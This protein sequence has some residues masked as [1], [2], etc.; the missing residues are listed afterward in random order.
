MVLRVTAPM[1]PVGEGSPR[2]TVMCTTFTTACERTQRS[3]GSAQPSVWDAQRLDR[4]GAV[5]GAGSCPRGTALET[6]GTAFRES[7]SLEVSCES[8]LFMFHQSR[9]P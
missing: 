5:P 2:C 4:R 3:H 8:F 7:L 9:P 1:S 6:L